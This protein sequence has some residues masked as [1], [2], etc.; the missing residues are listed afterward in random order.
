[1][2]AVHVPVPPHKVAPPQ[3]MPFC[4]AVNV[5][6]PVLV[7]QLFTSHALAVAGQVTTV[8]GLTTH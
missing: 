8:V 1:M 2:P 7:S 6:A 4:A 3:G 5:H